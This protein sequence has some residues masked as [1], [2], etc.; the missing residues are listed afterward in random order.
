MISVFYNGFKSI[1]VTLT[2]TYTIVMKENLFGL[3]QFQL[4]VIISTV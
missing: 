4:T 2:K 3:A 1:N